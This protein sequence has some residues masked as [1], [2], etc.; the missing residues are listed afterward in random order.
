M[1]GGLAYLN[2]PRKEI[3]LAQRNDFGDAWD[4]SWGMD[5]ARQPWHLKAWL[6]ELG[7]K[8]SDLER[9]LGMNK[10][11]ASLLARN[12]Q[13]YDQD[14][15][16]AVAEYLGVKPYELLM[17]PQEALAL[18]QFRA[19]AAQIADF[20]PEPEGPPPGTPQDEFS[21]IRIS[22]RKE[23]QPGRRTGTSG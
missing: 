14:D 4:Y 9:D 13:P 3:C 16:S 6:K 12:I 18:R 1:S 22:R 2:E 20:T 5:V 15:I 10:A 19:S 11:K 7:K 17:H 21:S 23:S 8:Q